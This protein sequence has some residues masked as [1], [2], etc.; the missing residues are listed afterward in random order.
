MSVGSLDVKTAFLYAELNEEEDG[1]LVVQPPSLL[2]RMGLVE[3]GI[4][5]KLKKALYG[6]R[7]APKRWSQERDRV[8]QDQQVDLDGKMASMKQ[9]KASQGVWKVIYDNEVVGYFLVYVDD[10]LF[11]AKTECILATMASFGKNWECTYVGILVHDGATTD[12][13]VQ[14]LVFLS[15]TIE[16][17]SG[18]TILHQ[19]AYLDN[20]LRQRHIKTGRPALPEVE[21]GK[22]P[23]VSAEERNTI[24]YQE[25]LKKAQAEVGSLQ[26]LA[27]KTRP[28]IA[29]ITAI[30]ASLQ[31][32]NPVLAIDYCRETWRYL[33]NTSDMCMNLITV[34]DKFKVRI[35][36]DASFAPGGDRSRTG[37]IIRVAGAI[38]HWASNRQSGSVLSAH[39]AELNGAITGT[40][41]GI[42]IREIVQDMVGTSVTLKL[43]Q[44]NQATIAT[45]MHEV[46]S[47]RT[48]HYALRAAGIRDLVA[49]QQITVEHVRGVSIIADPLTKVL[50]N[51]KLME[52]YEKLQLRKHRQTSL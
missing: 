7:C 26:W 11:V 38:V 44:D 21:E 40:K 35:S 12:L 3:P 14:S 34:P 2:V 31:S 49:E 32:R 46:T 22:A 6:L 52:S 51:I 30:C 20:K 42:A 1:I 10:I 13:A 45:I 48:R 43:D 4:M 50:P 23:P 33:Y 24:L 19:H 36:A 41:V 8:L 28:D 15:I 29:V 9:C 18:G 17:C 37:V 39:E 5:W 16:S 47:W 25:N 27:L